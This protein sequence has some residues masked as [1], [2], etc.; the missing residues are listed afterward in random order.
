MLG[1]LIVDSG[2]ITEEQLE[3][4]LLEQRVSRKRLG[5]ILVANRVIT[6]PDLTAALL[7]QIEGGGS[8]RS[9]ADLDVDLEPE[10]PRKRRFRRKRG[11]ED[12]DMTRNGSSSAERDPAAA[13]ADV[14]RDLQGIMETHLRSLREE[15]EAAA[16]ELDAARAELAARTARIAELEA[17]LRATEHERQLLASGLRAEI[18]ELESALQTAQL[19][20]SASPAPIVVE[21]PPPVLSGASAAGYLLLAPGGPNGHE[22]R[23]LPGDPPPVGR[24]IE[25]AGR[26]F[27]VASHRR[28]PLGFDDRVCVHLQPR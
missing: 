14:L 3:D 17:R 25:Y 7:A 8:S 13:R 27:L 1:E 12:D 5:A 22:L 6:P 19:G 21:P 23:E 26:R 10:Q 11:A 4:A 15:F 20:A 2:L 28:S 24:E 18:G 16:A 9:A